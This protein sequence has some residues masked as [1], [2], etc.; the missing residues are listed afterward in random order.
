MYDRYIVQDIIKEIAQ[1]SPLDKSFKGLSA[2]SDTP[3]CSAHAS[4]QCLSPTTR[5]VCR[6]SQSC[7]CQT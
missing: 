4:L 7:C 3:I 5:I 1:N 2:P 6:S